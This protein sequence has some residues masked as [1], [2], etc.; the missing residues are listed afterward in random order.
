MLYWICGQSSL[1]PD[2]KLITQ[3]FLRSQINEE[4]LD[5]PSFSTLKQYFTTDAW[6]AVLQKG[7]YMCNNLSKV[8]QKY[9]CM[10]VQVDYKR[11]HAYHT[12]VN[13]I[14]EDWKCHQCSLVT[15]KLNMIACDVCEKWYHW[16]VLVI[17]VCK[18]YLHCTRNL[19]VQLTNQS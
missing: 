2:G 1:P 5:A 9:T 19:Y 15:A 13:L 3:S 8:T 4:I 10:Y 18:C 6:M 16:Y 7:T 17:T 11:L 14:R 12:S